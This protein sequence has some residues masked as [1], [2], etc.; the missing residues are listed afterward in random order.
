M[1]L[2]RASVAV[3]LL[4]MTPVAGAGD[5]PAFSTPD[6]ADGVLRAK[7]L[8]FRLHYDTARWDIRPQRS[9]LAL[10]A[11]V[12]HRDGAV[13]GAFDYRRE[14]LTEAELRER[15]AAELEAAFE[16]HAV[17]GFE[18]RRVNG[19]EVLF[20]RAHATTADGADV[21]VRSYLWRGAEGT[22]DYGLVVD[23]AHFD[24][25]REHMIDLLNGFDRG[26][27]GESGE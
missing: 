18:R 26:G 21:V 23:A 13:S 16:S 17:E 24:E 14:P 9:Q 19:H 2:I 3:L 22:A 10:L 11:R 12:I 6:A 27:E 4:S 8:P 5:P 1:R 7:E 20:M 25:H 15:E